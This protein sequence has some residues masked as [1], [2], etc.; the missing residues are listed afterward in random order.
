MNEKCK[1]GGLLD[2][3]WIAPHRYPNELSSLIKAIDARQ[4]QKTNLNDL[5]AALAVQ[6]QE[7]LSKEQKRILLDWQL[8]D[9]LKVEK[10]PEYDLVSLFECQVPES[11]RAKVL[12]SISE[13]QL[14]EGCNGNCNFCLFG[15]KSG[16]TGKFSYDSICTFLEKYGG[17]LNESLTFY[18]DS[19]PF[20]YRDT[21]GHSYID[22]YKAYRKIRP[23]CFHFVSTALPRDS[24][25]EFIKFMLEIFDEAK[26][27]GINKIRTKVRLSI[28]N[29]NIN[30]IA[31]TLELLYENLVTLGC[32][33]IDID[34]FFYTILDLA[35]IRPQ[36]V[37]QQINEFNPFL[38][39][40]YLSCTDSMLI[41][42][43]E[44][45][46][47][48][49]TMVIPTIYTAAGQ[50]MTLYKKE[51]GIINPISIFN[52]QAGGD[53]LG[54]IPVIEAHYPVKYLDVLIPEAQSE[55]GAL[56]TFDSDNIINLSLHLA[57]DCFSLGNL[58]NALK[59]INRAPFI[60]DNADE[61][62][63]DFYLRAKESL[64]KRLPRVQNRILE[65]H[66]QLKNT[67]E[68]NN[69]NVEMLEYML[70]LAETYYYK[71][72][73]IL[74]LMQNNETKEKIAQVA[75]AISQW[76]EMPI[77]KLIH[78]LNYLIAPQAIT[79]I[80]QE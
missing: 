69:K 43:A 49:T 66:S 48:V 3:Y 64:S 72:S 14:T 74:S 59:R 17:F 12:A 1:H 50:I 32:S 27:K 8:P 65:A 61:K 79:T 52:Y 42:P 46:V 19:D 63:D 7:K 5:K 15:V 51:L 20:D 77:P 62:L 68:L 36:S 16:V 35:R 45:P 11:E 76:Y 2:K 31:L 37:G 58:F 47:R 22:V 44:E 38:N 25:N 57:R 29:H 39:V 73:S 67:L 26:Q 55:S 70:K 4:L 78:F 33:Q 40:G 18:L 24:Q 9:K 34:L 30:R 75:S 41:V 53:G 10:T 28:S 56:Y 6:A 71:L 54:S 23:N 21:V 13:I 80:V 60:D